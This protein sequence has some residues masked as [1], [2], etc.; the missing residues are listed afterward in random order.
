MKTT[1]DIPEKILK[2]TVRFSGASTKRE[3]V[4]GALKEYNQR[5]RISQ[6]SKYIGTFENFMTAD[7]LKRLREQS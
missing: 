4:V 1:I 2:E 7:E 3:A 5:R 6:L